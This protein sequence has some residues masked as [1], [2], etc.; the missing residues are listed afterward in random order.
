MTIWVCSTCSHSFAIGKKDKWRVSYKTEFTKGKIQ[1]KK[2]S[3]S[4]EIIN[5]GVQIVTT[6]QEEGGLQ[7]WDYYLRLV[8]SAF[9]G[10]LPLR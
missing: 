2:G 7:H 3:H 9:C 5:S 10:T 1:R 8:A 6:V 4:N